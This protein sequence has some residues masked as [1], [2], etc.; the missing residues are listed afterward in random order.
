MK[1][2]CPSC[3]EERIVLY[4]KEK[5]T[6]E[7]THCHRDV[8]LAPMTVRWMKQTTAEHMVPLANSNANVMV[9]CPTCRKQVDVKVDG[10]NVYCKLCGRQLEV[11]P[12]TRSI[13][14]INKKRYTE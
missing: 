8:E 12:F 4:N 11:T 7:C 6:P 9:D 5:D 3:N 1:T 14:M 10:N 2:M 13:I